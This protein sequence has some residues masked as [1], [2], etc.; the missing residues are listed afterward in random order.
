MR[1]CQQA[2]LFQVNRLAPGGYIDPD[3]SADKGKAGR[4]YKAQPTERSAFETGSDTAKKVT[5]R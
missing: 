4:D 2:L 1:A 3:E 5:S